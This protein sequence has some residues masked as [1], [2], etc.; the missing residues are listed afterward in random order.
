MATAPAPRPAKEIDYPT[1][2]GRPMAETEVH[3]DLMVDSIQT[4]QHWFAADPMVC[5]SGNLLVYYEEGNRRRHVAPDVFVAKGVRKEVR[6]YFLLW[7][8]AKGLDA[9][10]E[11]TSSS[12]RKVDL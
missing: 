3:R 12:T 7:K 4:L 10:I 6:K 2:D 8:E 11:L 5:V 1:S 9:V